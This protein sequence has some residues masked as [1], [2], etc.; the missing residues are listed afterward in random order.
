MLSITSLLVLAVKNEFPIMTERYW[1]FYIE[2]YSEILKIFVH[3]I[4]PN[5]LYGGRGSRMFTLT[6]FPFFGR[7][8]HYF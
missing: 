1:I 3:P 6:C 4:I 5:S 2:H 8:I 7:F